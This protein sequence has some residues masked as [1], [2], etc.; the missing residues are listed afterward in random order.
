M[1]KKRTNTPYRVRKIVA[2]TINEGIF[3]LEKTTRAT[4]FKN[5]EKNRETELDEVYMEFRGFN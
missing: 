5:S 1:I 3:G 4:T 2:I